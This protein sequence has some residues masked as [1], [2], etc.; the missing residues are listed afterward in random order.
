M[1]QMFLPGMP[2]GAIR[3]NSAVSLLLKEGHVTW[4]VGDDNYFSYPAD[5]LAGRRLAL[6]TLMEN[7]H[8]RPSQ[9]TAA[10]GTP[11]STLMRWCRQLAERGAG[12]FYQPRAVRGG[13]VITSEK[14]AECARLFQAGK[15]IAEVA[16]LAGISESTLRKAVT[17]GRVVRGVAPD[18]AVPA[19]ASSTK[20]KRSQQDA[21]AS[22]GMGTACTR[23]EARTAA[24]IGLAGG[25]ATRFE[26]ATD[27]ALGGVLCGL[28]ALCANGLFTGLDRHLSLP[29]GYYTTM[30]IL[31]VLG[32]M[33]LARIRRPEQLRHHPPGELGKTIGLDRIPEVRTLRE[34]IAHLATTGNPGKWMRELSADWMKQD[35]TEAGY[36]YIDG[37][38]RVYHGTDAVLPRRYVS[39][40]KLCLR[41]TTDYWVNDAL[42]RPFFVVSKAVTEGLGTALIEEILPELLATVPGQPDAAQL[43]ADPLLHRFVVIFDREGSNYKLL[44]QLW[45]QRV[46][47]ITYRKNVTDTWPESEFQDTQVPSPGGEVTTMRLATRQ[48]QIT[49]RK[50]PPVPL[51]E[52]RRLTPS[53]HQTAIITTARHLASPTIAGRMFSRWC[54]E[55]YFGYMMEHYDIDGLTQYGSEEMDGTTVVINPAWRDLDKQI[56]RLNTQLRRHQ[57]KLGAAA[58]IDPDNPKSIQHRATLHE[59]IQALQTQRED[60]KTH[61]RAT[62]RKVAIA[63]LPED[64]RPRQLLPLTKTLTDTVKM[65]AYRAETAL[66]GLLRPH[67]ANE[68][69]ARALIRELFVS[70]ADLVPDNAAG[71]LTISIHRMATPV[72]DRAIALLLADLTEANFHH[73]ETNHRFIY[74][75]V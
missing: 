40:Q 70:S 21:A 10:L 1:P 38:V 31:C 53:G 47:A 54:Q 6:A 9:I 73:P 50:A 60:L 45:K 66:V 26:P 68:A 34:K 16:R 14:S 43:A 12:S 11:R 55:N 52:V 5:D 39:R 56:T 20:S 32:F 51:I 23:V 4:F 62:P 17:A 63:D 29:K 19:E 44:S 33:A 35:P 72:H 48:T 67:L 74:Q 75:L 8:A 65:I 61:R 27:I 69:E 64:Q 18:P 46:G 22:Q 2:D 30:H 28:P 7:G 37:H 71:T 41:G 15:S 42:G 57:A 3:I 49:A 24:A 58:P 36:L 13:T 59:T 25:A